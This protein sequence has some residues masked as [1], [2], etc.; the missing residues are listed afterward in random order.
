M[1]IIT[2]NKGTDQEKTYELSVSFNTV[3]DSDIMDEF[4]NTMTMFQDMRGGENADGEEEVSILPLLKPFFGSLRNI[5]FAVLQDN[6]ADE[7]KT[8][9]DA[10]TLIDKLTREKDANG[11]PVYDLF[12]IF[13]LVT[14][15]FEDAGFLSGDQETEVVESNIV[16]IAKQ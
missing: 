4:Q 7:I 1:A 6:H 3:A 14:E 11:K 5:F 2:I 8:V 16:P 12:G 9:K 15:C 13:D 10:G